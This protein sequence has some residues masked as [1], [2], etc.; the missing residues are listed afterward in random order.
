MSETHEKLILEDQV[1][2]LGRLVQ[3]SDWPAALSTLRAMERE[4][5][6]R[7]QQQRVEHVRGPRD[8]RWWQ[9]YT[10]SPELK[11]E[12]QAATRDLNAALGRALAQIASESR[13]DLAR[14][15]GLD[16]AT[17][18]GAELADRLLHRHLSPV[19]SIHAAAGAADS[20]PRDAAL[21]ALEDALAQRGHGMEAFQPARPTSS[22][23]R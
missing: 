13:S 14:G 20:E 16:P 21:D 18:R 3:A 8:G 9:L 4:I 17:A 23:S 15:L 22:R 12:V 6:L 10:S 5:A 1:D 19:M 2:A 7:Q 11:A